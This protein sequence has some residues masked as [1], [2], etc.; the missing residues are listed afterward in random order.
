M[1]VVRFT[2]PGVLMA[3]L[4]VLHCPEC[5]LAIF[6]SRQATHCRRLLQSMSAYH[7]LVLFQV[8]NFSRHHLYVSCDLHLYAEGLFSDD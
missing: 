6:S 2:E 5:M 7:A 4:T 1:A 3:L 8:V